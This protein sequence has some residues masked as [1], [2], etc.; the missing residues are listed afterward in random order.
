MTNITF[1]ATKV[2]T[3]TYKFEKLNSLDLSTI[4][5]VTNNNSTLFDDMQ[6]YLN[7][8][9]ESELMGFDSFDELEEYL[10]DYIN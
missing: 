3:G 9:D 2:S 7:D 5:E 10:N 8:G 1:S 4:A 6:E